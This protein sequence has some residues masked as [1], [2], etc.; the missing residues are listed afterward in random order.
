MTCPKE[1][2]KLFEERG[3]DNFFQSPD[4]YEIL[5]KSPD[6]VPLLV[7]SKS[8]GLL[9]WQSTRKLGGINMGHASTKGEPIAESA[10]E[11]R[12]LL[13]DASKA[14]K[15]SPI[16]IRIY[17]FGDA[18]YLKDTVD[19][20]K[21]IKESWL[22]VL[23]D[24]DRDD[25]YENMNRKRRWAIRTAEKNLEHDMEY[26]FDAERVWKMLNILTTRKKIEMQSQ[27]FLN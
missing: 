1:Y 14:R 4:A 27:E 26:E 21:I 8:N 10:G 5:E 20:K 23:I 25:V 12:K 18:K 9:A 7:F 2:K 19:K 13:D 22:D 24:I 15:P 11:M 6:F 3:N 17:P 16:Y